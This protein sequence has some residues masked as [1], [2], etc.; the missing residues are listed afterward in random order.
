MVLHMSRP[1]KNPKTG[2]F[3]FRQKTPADLREIFGKAEVGWS[4]RTKDETEAK[5]RHAEALQKQSRIWQAMRNGPAP[6]PHKQL[7]VLSGE[8]YRSLTNMVEDEPGEPSYWRLMLTKFSEETMS[9]ASVERW[10]GAEAD[11]LLSEAGLSAD[12]YS[13]TRLCEELHKVWLQ[14]SSF[15]LQRSQGDYS[16]DPKANRFPKRDEERPAALSAKH[17][18][19]ISSLFSMWERDHFANGKPK[20]TADDFRQKINSLIAFVGHDDAIRLTGTD[21]SDWCDHLRHEQKLA[22]KTVRDKYLAAVRVVFSTAVGKRKLFDNPAE[23]VKVSVPKA[24]KTRPKGF[25]DEEAQA[26]LSA[27]L[28]DPSELGSLA[29]SNKTAIRWVP[30]I[31][32]YTGARVSEI[33][34]LRKDDITSEYGISCFR[35][36]PEAGSVKTGQYRVVPVHQHLLDMGL[37]DFIAA[38]QSGPLFYTPRKT[39]EKAAIRAQNVGK[40]VGDWVRK[41]AG[42][43]DPR[44]WPNHG[45]RHRFKTVARDVDIAPEYSDAITGH[46]DGR[47][48]THYGETTLKALWREMQKIPRYNLR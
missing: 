7:L 34:Q 40:K 45:W 23:G 22:A 39:G 38:Q 46:E 48:S 12:D 47:A 21:I 14:W 15:Q 16:P 2:V 42:V 17:T 24:L 44:V 1:H 4:L 31:C 6:I 26:I 37:L 28:R 18:V 36:T 9:R 25:T 29:E 41:V 5:L 3:Y 32:A 43:D 13:R 11:R 27:S 8:F 35:I 33:A 30:W 20:K 10:F 19:S